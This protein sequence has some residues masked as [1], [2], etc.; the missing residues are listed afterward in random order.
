M[1]ASTY[2]LI[3]LNSFRDS[4]GVLTPIDF[5]KQI[6]FLPKRTFILSDS[7]LETIRGEHAHRDCVQAIQCLR[8]EVEISIDNGAEKSV[9]KLSRIEYVLLIPTLHW[10]SLKFLETNS[11]VIVYASHPYEEKDYLRNYDEFIGLMTR[12]NRGNT[13]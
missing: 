5:E 12:L 11:Q 3:S 1:D 7:S 10:I 2:R 4:R 9:E 6:D 8:G 13:E